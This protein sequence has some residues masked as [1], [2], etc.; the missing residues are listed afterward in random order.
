VPDGGDVRAQSDGE[1]PPS[2][3]VIV[4]GLQVLVGL[5]SLDEAR[6]VMESHRSLVDADDDRLTGLLD[7]SR[8]WYLERAAGAPRARWTYADL[9]AT[10]ARHRRDVVVASPGLT[11]DAEAKSR[12]AYWGITCRFYLIDAAVAQLAL[13]RAQDALDL[14]DLVVQSVGPTPATL[15]M[16]ARA[17]TGLQI[18]AGTLGSEQTRATAALRF[19]ALLVGLQP[20]DRR[21]LQM[22]LQQEFEAAHNEQQRALEPEVSQGPVEEADGSQVRER[23]VIRYLKVLLE[24]AR[25]QPDG[26][27]DTNVIPYLVG[28]P[29]V[30]ALDD[31]AKQLAT[32]RLSL[33]ADTSPE[34]GD[35]AA[36]LNYD[37]LQL[38]GSSAS[39][40]T[41]ARYIRGLNASRS[42]LRLP[43]NQRSLPVLRTAAADLA[44]VEPRLVARGEDIGAASAAVFY[45]SCLLNFAD[46]LAALAAAEHALEVLARL[47]E[48][49]SALTLTVMATGNYA[50]G[51][52]KLG[53]SLEALEQYFHAR[54]LA[55][56]SG[57]PG[58]IRQSL[59]D[60][61]ALSAQLGRSDVAAAAASAEAQIKLGSGDV[62]GAARAYVTISDYAVIHDNSEAR[63]MALRAADDL[64]GQ[65]PADQCDRDWLLICSDT[66]LR[67]AGQWISDIRPS[68][69][70]PALEHALARSELGRQAAVSAN[71]ADRVGEAWIMMARAHFAAGQLDQA[72][73]DMATSSQVPAT[74]SVTAERAEVKGVIARQLNHFDDAIQDFTRAVVGYGACGQKAKESTALVSLGATYELQGEPASALV[75]YERAE[76]LVRS[77]RQS[78]LA[79]GTRVRFRQQ[80]DDLYD[81]LVEL[82]ASKSVAT[83]HP[84]MA[85]LNIERAKARSF[86]EMIGLAPLHI[87]HPSPEAA[88]LLAEE[89]VLIEQLRAARLIVL[90]ASTEADLNQSDTGARSESRLE[91]IWR[92]LAPVLPDYVALR[93]GSVPSWREFRDC[94]I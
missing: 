72:V 36:R 16:L 91:E 41:S 15:W 22:A 31:L 61:L 76:D 78:M 8:R 81:R 45:S 19:Q 48:H 23:A 40:L 1:Q 87:S 11:T 68:S 9:A 4:S 58:L 84:E 63:T 56:R 69:P 28:S 46:G 3:I 32:Y 55:V 25:R 24:T 34:T 85:W 49:P 50:N 47:S 26:V 89:A 29:E 86:S 79:D 18:A 60:V 80:Y 57:D 10:A 44:E 90:D 33:M 20:A 51:L 53:R 39:V 30:A 13:G 65:V 82:T 64:L 92:D 12:F 17:L 75:A 62:K 77:Q 14:F 74:D 2:N 54:E 21:R 7:E 6:A 27:V 42:Q 83:Y 37:C 43:Q 73:A 67:Q 52:R 71:D 35:R 59:G 38:I 93:R 66:A 88:E 5:L 70:S 94:L